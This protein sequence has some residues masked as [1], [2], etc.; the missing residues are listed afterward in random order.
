[1]CKHREHFRA[2]GN[3][4]YT[5]GAPASYRQSHC[6]AAAER[7]DRAGELQIFGSQTAQDAFTRNS[8][9][10]SDGTRRRN[11]WVS[12]VEPGEPKNRHGRPLR[13]GGSTGAPLGTVPWP[14]RGVPSGADSSGCIPLGGIRP[15]VVAVHHDA[16]GR[17][18]VGRRRGLGNRHPHHP[19]ANLAEAGV[20]LVRLM[21][22][23]RRAPAAHHREWPGTARSCSESAC[24]KPGSTAR[25]HGRCH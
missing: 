5:A 6:D 19:V 25:P 24:K 8:M 7:V 17:G 16:P 4:I 11:T 21:L 12:A 15:G 18:C 1:M 23:R 22:R 14:R 10:S 2:A 13:I 9:S 3:T 20:R